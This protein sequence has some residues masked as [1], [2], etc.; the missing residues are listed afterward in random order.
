MD[1]CY[2]PSRLERWVDGSF[3][4][5][6]SDGVRKFYSDGK[7]GYRR[8]RVSNVPSFDNGGK[9]VTFDGYTVDI[10]KRPL[11]YDFPEFC[12]LSIGNLRRERIV[13]TRTIREKREGGIHFIGYKKVEIKIDY[14][15]DEVRVTE[16][17]G[18]RPASEKRRF[19]VGD[20]RRIEGYVNRVLHS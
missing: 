1:V 10:T 8:Q 16:L 12:L 7:G 14:T 9:V 3:V 5:V 17:V 13:V 11:D 15:L 4:D 19:G 6:A 20:L 2:K 18:N